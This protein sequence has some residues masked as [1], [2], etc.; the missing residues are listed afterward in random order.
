MANVVVYTEEQLHLGTYVTEFPF[1]NKKV[2]IACKDKYAI[3]Y[4]KRL[5]ELGYLSRQERFDLSSKSKVQNDL[6]VDERSIKNGNT[7]YP[8]HTS[9]EYRPYGRSLDKIEVE[10]NKEIKVLPPLDV[11]SQFIS[12]YYTM[13]ENEFP[14]LW[15]IPFVN[16]SPI[17]PGDDFVLPYSIPENRKIIVYING[18]KKCWN[19]AEYRIKWFLLNKINEPDPNNPFMTVTTYYNLKD[20]C[21]HHDMGSVAREICK[22]PTGSFYEPL[23]GKHIVF[24]EL[25]KVLVQNNTGNTWTDFFPVLNFV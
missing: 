22:V 19:L 3:G 14:D 2:V 9:T 16:I 17:E 23:L 13:G 1:S 11:K 4:H 12:R 6:D 20:Y 10:S 8:Y 25:R 24:S 7:Y 15:Q 5:K 18:C 21:L